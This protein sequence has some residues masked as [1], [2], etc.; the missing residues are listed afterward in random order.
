[1]RKML[2]LAAGILVIAV[3]AA[4][5]AF[6]YNRIPSVRY[7]TASSQPGTQ[8]VS[9]T[10][11]ILACSRAE[12]YITSPVVTD[13][14]LVSVGDQVEPGTVLCTINLPATGLLLTSPELTSDFIKACLEGGEGQDLQSL[15]SGSLLTSENGLQLAAAPE[16]TSAIS[17]TVTAV[18]LQ[19]DSLYNS[20]QAAVVVED[21]SEL[22]AELY[23]P[24]ASAGEIRPGDRVLMQGAGITGEISGEVVS[25]NPS[26]VQSLES[27]TLQVLVPVQ[28]RLTSDAKGARPN[29]AVTGKIFSRSEAD[30]LFIPY[31]AICQDEE[32]QEYVWVLSGY[33][34]A[35]RR[36]VTTGEETAEST[37]ILT[38]ITAD[39][40]VLVGE[41]LR[42]GQQVRLEGYY[43]G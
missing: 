27:G 8:A 34:T 11:Q 40:I 21:L 42:S 13:Q 36:E 9:C 43:E 7:L 29:Y 35:V 38:G 37:Q 19:S 41:E 32:N 2:I 5:P 28:V 33:G 17:G 39:D 16:Y 22:Q 30:G 10:G 25:V 14:V 24:Q 31:Q 20:P 23:V 1:M 26:A 12:T 4:L 15:L 6:Y 18:N 3:S